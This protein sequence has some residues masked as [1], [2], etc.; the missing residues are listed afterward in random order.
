MDLSHF[1]DPEVD[2]RNRSELDSHADTCVAGANTVPLWYTD[3]K[4]SVS[5]FIGEYTP[6]EDILIASVAAA[7][8]NPIDGSPLILVI[9]EALYFGERMSH[10]LLCPNQLQ[11]FGLI[12]NDVPKIYDINS[13]ILPGQVELLLQMRGFIS[14]LETRK[15]TEVEIQTCPRYELTSA[16]SWD[17]YSTGGGKL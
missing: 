11:D 14:Y 1:Y 15:P 9:N 3:V 8:D 12:V 5:P 2:D 7:R 6:L 13:I 17:P 10:S 4:V 16:A